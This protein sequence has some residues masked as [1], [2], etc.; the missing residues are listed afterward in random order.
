MQNK[1]KP[2]GTEE[3]SRRLKELTQIGIALTSERDLDKLLEKIVTEARSF[4]HADGGS[5]YIKEE[6]HLHFRIS[7]NETL[8]RRLGKKKARLLF[9]PF[10]LPLS[11]KSIA[12]Y[13]AI[14]GETL[15]V[16]DVYL[17]DSSVPYQINKDFDKTNDYRT[18]SM[19]AVP[20]KDIEGAVLGVLQLINALDESAGVV[21]FSKEIED[22]TLSL[23]SQAAIAVKNA[24]LTAR[25][26]KAYLDTIYHLSVAAEYRDE[27]TGQHIRRISN[28]SKV[29][30]AHLH[31]S[32]AQQERILYASPMHDVGKLGIPDAVLQKKG[33]L[34]P[35]EWKIMQNH[36][37]IGAQ[38]LHDPDSEI[39]TLSEEIALSHHE[40]LNGTGYPQ[41]LKGKEIPL[42]ARIVAVADVFDALVSKRHYKPPFSVEKVLEIIKESSG[43]DL[44]PEVVNAFL[45]GLDEILRI[46]EKYGDEEV[47]HEDPGTN[48]RTET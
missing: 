41:H 46:R 22:L 29:I 34:S 20:M 18:Q 25:L 33:K 43:K 16:A 48:V 36:P 27:D 39:L 19:L 2:I 8:E 45:K 28:Y 7:Q 44:D 30:A 47:T 4:A 12:G 31:W 5:L 42:S 23:A 13:V 21:S 24:Q 1:E 35:E 11:E 38:I 3:L 6:D 37:F 15:N 9:R 32:E 14:S 10:E 26:K 17:L 40:K